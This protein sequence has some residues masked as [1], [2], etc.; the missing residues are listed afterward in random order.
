MLLVF[1]VV[2]TSELTI[3]QQVEEFSVTENNKKQFFRNS[4]RYST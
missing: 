2:R 3:S 4:E 1:L